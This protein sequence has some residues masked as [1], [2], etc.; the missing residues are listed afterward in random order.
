MVANLSQNF[1]LFD[2]EGRPL[3][4]QLKVRFTEFLNREDDARK[5]D[6]EA[7]TRVVR[8]GDSLANI[9][10]D[11]YRDPGAWRVISEIRARPSLSSKWATSSRS[12]CAFANRFGS[13][14]RVSTQA[15]EHGQMRRGPRARGSAPA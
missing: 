15:L 6:P 13:A 8:R 11:V 2:E 1:V 5:T 7:T 14:T 4:A 9:A 12:R 3:R 10:A